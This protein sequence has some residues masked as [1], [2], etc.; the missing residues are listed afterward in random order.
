[1]QK[2]YRNCD[3]IPIENFHK[4]LNDKNYGW[5]FV[6]YDGFED[7]DVPESI[8]NAWEDIY[9]EFIVISDDQTLTLYYEL[10][11]DV[12]YLSR[13]YEIVLELLKTLAKGQISESLKQDYILELRQWGFKIDKNKDLSKELDKKIR[14]LRASENRI[15]LKKFELENLTGESK[16]SMSLVE[17][18]VR[19]E[20]GLDRDLI[21]TKKT[22]A[23]KWV[24]LLKVL[25]ET[26]N[27]K[28]KLNGK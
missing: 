15:N 14:Q 9:N 3:E 23:S 4:I 24:F 2:H 5:M 1:M 20:Q 27:L 19:L 8:L 6:G 13:R 7:V 11:N 10:V 26:N 21:D 28:R 16:K 12:L 22:S 17:Q 18:T 25:E